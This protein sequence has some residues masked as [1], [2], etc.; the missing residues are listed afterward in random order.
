MICEKYGV[1]IEGD[2]LD[3]NGVK[4]YNFLKEKEA[5]R[6]TFWETYGDEILP[7]VYGENALAV[8]GPYEIEEYNVTTNSGDV[9]FDVGANLGLFSAYAEDKGCDVYAF[10]PGENC[11][12][13]LHEQQKLHPQMKIIPIGLS[14][15]IGEQVFYEAADCALSSFDKDR[16]DTENLVEKH[17]KTDTIDHYVEVNGITKVDYI[18]ADIEGEERNMLMG[19][20]NVL[21]IMEPKLAICTYHRTDDPLVLEQIIRAANPRYVVNH[22]WRKLYAYVPQ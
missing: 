8:D 21:K 5:I 19:A 17:I 13:Y 2:V 9:V 22:A 20:R 18:K 7:S 14:N 16:I 1:D 6:H 3:F 11:V 12:R 15:T 4:S 10:D